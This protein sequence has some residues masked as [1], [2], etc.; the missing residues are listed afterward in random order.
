M[1]LFIWSNLNSKVGSKPVH[2]SLSSEN[3]FVRQL[4]NDKGNLKPWEDIKLEIR[5][6]DTQ[7]IYCL[8]IIDALPNS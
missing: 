8:Q 1:I 3:N 6:K 5:L 7:K 4:F 2:F